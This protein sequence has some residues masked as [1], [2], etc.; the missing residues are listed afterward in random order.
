MET[1]STPLRIC[2]LSA[3]TP[4]L[5]ELLTEARLEVEVYALSTSSLSTSWSVLFF[6]EEMRMSGVM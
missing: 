1:T 4:V 2:V 3:A 6:L 5:F